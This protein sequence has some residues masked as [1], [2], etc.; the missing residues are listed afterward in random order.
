[1]PQINHLQVCYIETK[2]RKS[3]NRW[4]QRSKTIDLQTL[5]ATVVS[6]QSANPSSNH[7][8][9]QACCQEP[10]S[11]PRAKCRALGKER[12]AESRPSA[13]VGRRQNHICR[14]P[15]RRQRIPLGNRALCRGSGRRQ[16]KAVGNLWRQANDLHLPSILSRVRIWPSAKNYFAECRFCALG[17]FFFFAFFASK[18]FPWVYCCTLKYIL[19]FGAFLILLAIFN[20]FIS[21]TWILPGNS[22]L[23]CRCIEYW[24][25]V[26]QKIIFMVLHVVW[27]RIQWQMPNLAHRFHGTRRGTCV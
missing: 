1:M 2:N 9:K 25:W 17:K 20:K 3:V 27:D 8:R 19:K 4:L 6:Q 23:N 22:N 21:F 16:R 26:I 13:K 15:G 14:G 24:N 18:F 11:L 5:Q 7:Y 12:F 10:A